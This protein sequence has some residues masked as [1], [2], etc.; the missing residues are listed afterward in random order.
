MKKVFRLRSNTLLNHFLV[1]IQ[2]V[3]LSRHQNVLDWKNAS[4]LDS[5]LENFFV[6]V[7]NQFVADRKLK[8]KRAKE[9]NRM[10]TPK[11]RRVMA[12]NKLCFAGTDPFFTEDS[13]VIKQRKQNGRHDKYEKK[14]FYDV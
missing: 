6:F 10:M 13:S 4:S 9:T 12:S 8:Q 2:S 7:V 1:L 3:P 11:R 5:R 14:E